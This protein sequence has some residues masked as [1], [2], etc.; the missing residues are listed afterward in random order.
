MT[1]LADLFREINA[2]ML[3][4]HTAI[5]NYMKVLTLLIGTLFDNFR[6]PSNLSISQFNCPSM[7]FRLTIIVSYEDY[8]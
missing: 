1:I 3:M 4:K 2:E 7:L 5:S 6:G 8:M